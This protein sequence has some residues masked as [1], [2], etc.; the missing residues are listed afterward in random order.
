MCI[1]WPFKFRQL[2][3]NVIYNHSN[4]GMADVVLVN[5]NFTAETFVSTFSSLCSRRPRVLY[6]SLNF[7]SFDV[8]ANANKSD[9]IVP[10]TVKT[11]F[12]SINRYER[13]KNLSLALEA[14]DW[15]RNIVS[16]KEW[17]EVHLV[18]AG[19]L[20]TCTCKK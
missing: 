15:L 5:S 2:I 1:F 11:V 17:K 3:D 19:E 20:M 10:P 7:S 9:D 14:L 18:M 12:L 4:E 13:K 8:S 16:D 6:P